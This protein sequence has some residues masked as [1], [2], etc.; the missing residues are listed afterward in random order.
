MD[1]EEEYKVSE[2][3]LEKLSKSDLVCLYKSQLSL[4]AKLTGST[5]N[6]SDSRSH[7]TVLIEEGSSSRNEFSLSSG[8]SYESVGIASGTPGGS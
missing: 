8:S 2:E 4:S 7:L 1:S 5:H 6:D 3:D